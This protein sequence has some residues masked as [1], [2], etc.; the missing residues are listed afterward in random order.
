MPPILYRPQGRPNPD[1]TN[2]KGHPREWPIAPCRWWPG[3][4]SNCRRAVFSCENSLSLLIT[5][6]PTLA[7]NVRLV[8]PVL[9]STS[10]S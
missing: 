3:A 1:P 4:E 10:M 2:A 8:V 9:D 7:G 6:P 5:C